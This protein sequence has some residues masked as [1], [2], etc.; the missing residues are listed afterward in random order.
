MS[1]FGA[2]LIWIHFSGIFV[3]FSY[4]L[5]YLPVCQ[6]LVSYTF[7]QRIF[8][9]FGREGRHY[10][11]Y[12]YISMPLILYLHPPSK[13]KNKRPMGHIVH[14]RNQFTS[15]NTFQE[16]YDY[17]I[18]LIQRRK[19]KKYENLLILHLNKLESPSP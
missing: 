16:S 2:T 19:K 8:N 6:F 18:T 17:I 11:N 9:N 12:K 10:E 3:K 1:K 7:G 14:L 15:I 4:V 13:L 5:T